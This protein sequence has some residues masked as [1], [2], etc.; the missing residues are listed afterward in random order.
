MFAPAIAIPSAIISVLLFGIELGN[1]HWLH[2][3][4]TG[5]VMFLCLFCV[6]G[7]AHSTRARITVRGKLGRFLKRRLS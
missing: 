7:I 3:S 1:R 6:A 2:I 4:D 5:A